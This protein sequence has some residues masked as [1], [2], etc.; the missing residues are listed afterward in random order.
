V[1]RRK[2][3][4]L[5]TR[6]GVVIALVLVVLVAL[7]FFGSQHPDKAVNNQSS[8]EEFKEQTTQTENSTILNSQTK[9]E[10]NAVCEDYLF[11]EGDS[12]T[13][14]GHTILVDRISKQGVKLTVDGEEAMLFEGDSDRLGEGILIELNKGK[15]IY[16]G[17]DDVDN[18]VSLRIACE[19]QG[20]D[21]RDKYVREKGEAICETIYQNCKDSFSI[22]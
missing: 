21:S 6:L 10:S 22:E 11:N 4:S 19:T 17:V 7:I 2:K 12:R 13:I 20:E 9:Q 3:V 14:D 5:N 15:I 18:T 8:S 1:K 16:F